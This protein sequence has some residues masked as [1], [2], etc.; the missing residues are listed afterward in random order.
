[1]FNL[2]LHGYRTTD[3]LQRAYAD[4]QANSYSLGIKLVRGAYHEAEV[5]MFGG[6]KAPVFTRKPDTDQMYNR[7]IDWIL[8]R[9]A[10]DRALGETAT[11]RIG[12]LFGSHNEESVK[13]VM[14]GL[15]DHGL[16]EKTESG[17]LEVEE[18]VRK[19]VTLGQLFG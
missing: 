12:V 10:T 1:M 18:A 5:A 19:R 14:N 8:A 6:P 2:S 15:V 9:I 3:H 17:K 13:R 4:S 7:T 11:P 16:A